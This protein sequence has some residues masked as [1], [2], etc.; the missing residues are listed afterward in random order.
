MS[1]TKQDSARVGC[2]RLVRP[3]CFIAPRGYANPDGEYRSRFGFVWWF[4]IPRI[5]TQHADQ[6]NPRVLRAIWLCFAA[7]LDIWGQESR[8]CWPNK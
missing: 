7:G 3:N 1:T 6:W 2:G 4:W 8:D 5:H